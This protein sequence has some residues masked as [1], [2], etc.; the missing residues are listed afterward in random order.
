MDVDFMEAPREVETLGRDLKEEGCLTGG[1][2]DAKPLMVSQ[3]CL[4]GENSEG[5]SGNHF[6]ICA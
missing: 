6:K 4:S 1:G 3:F 5:E 2:R